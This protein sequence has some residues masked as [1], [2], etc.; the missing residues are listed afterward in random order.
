MWV[1]F[2]CFFAPPLV[3]LLIY[4]IIALPDVREEKRRRG[5]VKCRACGSYIAPKVERLIAYK[6]A[7]GVVY[8]EVM[9]CPVCGCQ[10]K[11]GYRR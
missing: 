11:L 8:D 1:F 7:D 4:A 3:I 9:D 5:K 6:C 10:I 2:V